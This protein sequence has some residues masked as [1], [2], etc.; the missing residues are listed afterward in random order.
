MVTLCFT[1]I[2]IEYIVIEYIVL[3]WYLNIYSKATKY[4]DQKGLKY[5]YIKDNDLFLFI[6]SAMYIHVSNI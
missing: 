6:K 5:M 3:L 2:V 4:Y 1:Y